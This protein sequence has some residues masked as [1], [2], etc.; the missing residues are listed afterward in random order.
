M[1]VISFAEGASAERIGGKGYALCTM[2]Q[3]GLPIPA[4]FCV[5]ADAMP[6]IDVDELRLALSTLQASSF[7]V[8]SSA[9]QEDRIRGSFAGIYPT[10]LNLR[11][12]PSVLQALR[13]IARSATAPAAIAYAQRRRL[14]ESD[15]VA[16]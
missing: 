12:A 9:T 11:D 8:R 14:A 7:A 4:G 15:S 3:A 5:V 13:D 1:N 16:A 2:W 6:A 10:H